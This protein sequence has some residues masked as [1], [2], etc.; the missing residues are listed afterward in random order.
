MRRAKTCDSV[1]GVMD[2][3][4]VREPFCCEKDHYVAEVELCWARELGD[5]GEPCNEIV[6]RP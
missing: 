4:P 3:R 5:Y 2:L 6:L 1:R